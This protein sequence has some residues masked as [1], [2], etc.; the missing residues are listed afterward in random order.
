MRN[1]ATELA[2][3]NNISFDCEMTRSLAH[4]LIVFSSDLI[5]VKGIFTARNYVSMQ[6]SVRSI[7]VCFY[8]LDASAAVIF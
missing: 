3:L 6:K 2:G 4:N 7:C 1:D 5:A 8:I